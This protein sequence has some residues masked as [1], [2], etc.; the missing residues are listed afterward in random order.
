MS[1]DA[2]A[3]VA[4]RGGTHLGDEIAG[5]LGLPLSI[6][7]HECTDDGEEMKLSVKENVRER[8]VFVVQGLGGTNAA[9]AAA[10]NDRLLELSLIIS[11]L[12]RASALRITA[13]VPYFAYGRQTRKMKSREPVSAADVASMLEEM[14]VD[15]IISVDLHNDHIA[16]FFSPSICV[17]NLTCVP[18]AAAFMWRRGLQSPVVV[19]PH[20]TGVARAQEF[21]AALKELDARQQA[22]HAEAAAAA[23]PGGSGS[24][25][26]LPAEPPKLAMLLSREGK[27][28]GKASAKKALE[29]IGSV[30]GCD[31][32][33]VDDMVD[34]GA[35]LARASRE[36]MARGA[37]R[38]LAFATHQVCSEGALERIADCDAE[39][40]V[41][42]NTTQQAALP[43]DHPVRR[44][45][46]V[47][48]AA[49]AVAHHIY[50]LV[51]AGSVQRPEID[52]HAAIHAMHGADKQ[53]GVGSPRAQDPVPHGA[54]SAEARFAADEADACGAAPGSP[55]PHPHPQ[56]PVVEAPSRAMKSLAGAS[57]EDELAD[58]CCGG[59]TS[60]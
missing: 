40:V 42:T 15:Q 38:V 12:R 52:P 16:G 33:V 56:R 49:P 8:D 9:G 41:M 39:L 43:R 18:A 29:L 35:S 6:A 55:Q 27:K 45:L 48:S 50:S 34:S 54:G 31:A 17:D 60:D 7:R 44:K 1:R 36:L 3:L 10:V 20:A 23:E 21:L 37:R 57:F 30:D 5:L 58:A 13:V 19:S 47:L 2:V 26:P 53:S 25:L 51:G 28:A 32:I 14:G 59:T 22:A 24:P 11:S 4:G 46:V